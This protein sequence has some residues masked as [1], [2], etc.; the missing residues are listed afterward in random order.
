MWLA[1]VIILVG[2]QPEMFI[3][4]EPFFSKDECMAAAMV[5][6]KIMRETGG[7]IGQVGCYHMDFREAATSCSGPSQ[8]D[9]RL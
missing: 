6:Y 1:F 7:V 2:G 5:D 9:I 4:P 8:S 3:S